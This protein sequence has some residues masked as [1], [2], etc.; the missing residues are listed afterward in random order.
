MQ[1]EI[2]QYKAQMEAVLFASGEPFPIARL[3][4]VLEVT[5]ERCF[6]LPPF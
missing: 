4:E 2:S 3:A 1:I 6:R 5:E